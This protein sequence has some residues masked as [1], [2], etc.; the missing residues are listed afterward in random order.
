M[1]VIFAGF[2][3]RDDY[4]LILAANRDEFYNR[5]TATAGWWE[6]TPEIFAGRDLVGGGTWLGVTRSGRFS[7]VTNY[8]E[9][10][11]K[12]GTI[13]RGFLVAD[14]LKGRETA[15]RYLDGVK[16]HADEFSGF[17]LI[18]GEVNKTRRELFYYSNRGGDVQELGPGIYGLSNHLLDTGWPKVVTGKARFAELLREG[19]LRKDAVFELLADEAKADDIVLPDTGVGI[20]IERALSAIFIKTPGYGTRSSTV[21]TIGPDSKFD[22]DERVA[23]G[24]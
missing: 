3:V 23:G 5:A 19:T 7:A 24:R 16:T 21:L 18:A 11:G 8:R 10:K 14:F 17:N 6:D 12:I 15:D 1:C 9:P 20:E 2:G 4:P 13:S 22:L